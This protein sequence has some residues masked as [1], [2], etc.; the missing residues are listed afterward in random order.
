MKVLIT[1]GAGFIGSHLVDYYLNQGAEV[2]ALDNLIT[3]REENIKHNFSNKKFRFIKGDV[4]DFPGLKEDIDLLLHFASPAS[5]FDYLRYPIETMKTAALGTINMLELARNKNAR[6]LLASTSEVYGDPLIHPQVEEYWGNVNPVGVRSVYDE[7]K[8]FAEALTV[9]YHRKYHL[10]INIVRIFNTYGE[11]M[12]P[13]DGRVIPTFIEQALKN[14]PITIFGDGTQ[15]RSFCYISDLIRGIACLAETDYP[16]PIN[17]GNPKEFTILQLAQKIKILC[18]SQ[19]TF[20]H[21]PLPEDDPHR[22]NPDIT[23]AKKI[24]KWEPVVDLDEGLKRVIAW[25]K[26]TL[27]ND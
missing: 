20:I 8:R 15:T 21:K 7:G 14:E 25:F 1:G 10:R 2:I 24:L 12:R 27:F 5:P 26:T 9:A 23:K 4:C 16:L 11:R 18:N 22:R 6:F 19:S 3:G 13:G 17:L